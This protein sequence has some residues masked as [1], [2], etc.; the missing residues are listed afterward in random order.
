MVVVLAPCKTGIV[1]ISST[2]IYKMVLVVTLCK[3]DMVIST[4]R[5]WWLPVRRP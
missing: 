1:A 2:C 4:T 3:T 5:W